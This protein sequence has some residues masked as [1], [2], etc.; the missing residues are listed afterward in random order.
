MLTGAAPFLLLVAGALGLRTT[1]R[2]SYLGPAALVVG[3]LLILFQLFS[4]TLGNS[5]LLGY[6]AS[7]AACIWFVKGA[8][9]RD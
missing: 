2:T 3:A 8:L 7:L 6:V 9:N 4:A 5:S 1:T